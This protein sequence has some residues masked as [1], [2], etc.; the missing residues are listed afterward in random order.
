MA[1]PVPCRYSCSFQSLLLRYCA[2][3]RLLRSQTNSAFAPQLIPVCPGVAGQSAGRIRVQYIEAAPLNQAQGP[4][5]MALQSSKTTLILSEEA[6]VK[7]QRTLIS[8]WVQ[9]KDENRI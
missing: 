6:A 9:K 2:A 7:L 3:Q 4:Y 8:N 1:V 5:S